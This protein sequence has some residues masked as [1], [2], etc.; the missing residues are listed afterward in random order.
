[1]IIQ[2]GWMEYYQI[3]IFYKH[4]GPSTKIERISSDQ[5][6]QGLYFIQNSKLC[7]IYIY[8]SHRSKL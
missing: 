1:M 5:Y 2:D 7:C 4:R 6:G 8:S 3:C